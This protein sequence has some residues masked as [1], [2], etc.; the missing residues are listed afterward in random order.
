M[1]LYILVIIIYYV[2][3]K[4]T[5]EVIMLLEIEEIQEQLKGRNFAEVGRAI[6]CTRCYVRYLAYGVHINPSYELYKK[7]SDYVVANPKKPSKL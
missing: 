3:V 5:T 7:L 6:G 4:L 2:K 1:T